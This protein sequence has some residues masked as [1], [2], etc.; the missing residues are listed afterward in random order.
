MYGPVTPT[1]LPESLELQSSPTSLCQ[2]A[3][4]GPSCNSLHSR[5][6]V[7][8]SISQLE[9]VWDIGDRAELAR[10][11][12]PEEET[13]RLWGMS[14]SSCLNQGT[15]VKIRVKE[16]KGENKVKDCVHMCI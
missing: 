9:S 1:V 13:T 14:G 2:Q 4:D 3:W 7:S 8:Q 10:E 16:N 5:I 11:R 12:E 6:L 15:C